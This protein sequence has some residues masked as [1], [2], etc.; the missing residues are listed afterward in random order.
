MSDPV[1]VRETLQQL[2]DAGLRISMDDFGTGY[3]SLSCLRE[4][5][6]NAIKIDQSFVATLG[7]DVQHVA[8]LDTIMSSPNTWAWTWS[9][10]ELRPTSRWP[11]SSP[12]RA[13]TAR[14]TFSRNPCPPRRPAGWST[15]ASTSATRRRPKNARPYRGVGFGT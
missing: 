4:I 6:L 2:R 11:R 5:P 14:A 7:S 12:S 1:P 9:P 3:S 10:R 13:P 8:I 15:P